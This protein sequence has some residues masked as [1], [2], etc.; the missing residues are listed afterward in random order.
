MTRASW[1]LYIACL[2]TVCYA[3]ILFSLHAERPMTRAGL[4]QRHA[5]GYVDVHQL[6]S[7]I[8]DDSWRSQIVIVIIK[9]PRV[10]TRVG[11]VRYTGLS[12]VQP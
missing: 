9:Q 3:L 11:I 6:I 12:N 7:L 2:L 8:S 1:L 10:V 4:K 5:I